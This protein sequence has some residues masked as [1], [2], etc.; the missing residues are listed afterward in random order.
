MRARAKGGFD[1]QT[2][3]LQQ[4]VIYGPVTSRRLGRSLGLNPLP[5]EIK[6]CSLN[7]RYCQYG[8]TGMLQ[9]PAANGGKFF[10][11][12]REI[13]DE[14]SRILAAMAKAK[15]PP[16][17]ITFSGNGEATLHPKF[18]EI[19][20]DVIG[21]R[22]TYAPECRTAILSNSTA[23]GS[24]IVREAIL[25]L[26]D[27]ILKLDAGTEETFKKLNAPA[28]GIL[29]SRVLAGLKAIGPRAIIQSLFVTGG[30][31]NTLPEEVGAW[32]R[33]VVSVAPREVQ[34]Y[35]LD[36]GPADGSLKPVPI[37]R[38]EAIAEELRAAGVAA[39]VFV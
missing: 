21:L 4:G 5:G 7:C 6:L 30:V 18:P 29:F 9:A 19:V 38:L 33:A 8:W 31:D 15:K 37:K 32:L 20:S 35:T 13:F 14:L 39:R 36:R 11:A 26:D 17:T 2:I 34:I 10:P 3:P 1:R 22:D 12:R 24:K 27:P 23:L 16:D 28:P 25:K